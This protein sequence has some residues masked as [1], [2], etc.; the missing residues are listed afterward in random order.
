MINSKISIAKLIGTKVILDLNS[1]DKENAIKELLEHL[2]KIDKL[3]HKK[4]EL[5]DKLYEEIIERE[6]LSSTGIG[7][8]I[9]IPHIR[10]QYVEKPHLIVGVCKS[11]I[12][13]DSI[14]GRPVKMIFLLVAPKNHCQQNI[15]I[16]STM[17][18]ILKNEETRQNL[19]DSDSPKAFVNV[20][21]KAEEGI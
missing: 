20:I 18:R 19:L 13:Y 16:L 4:I 7:F 3:K 10:T 6:K 14:D 8:E 5:L 15:E 9:A 21:K 1:T 11:G 17:A 12:E 2:I